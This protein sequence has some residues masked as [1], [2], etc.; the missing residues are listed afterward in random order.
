MKLREESG[1]QAAVDGFAHEHIA[2]GLLMKKYQNVSLVDFPLSTFDII[3]VIEDESGTN[4]IIR[5]Q[6]KTATTSVRFTGGSRGGV[7]REY[8]SG[9]KQYTQSTRT[10]DVVVGV[11]PVDKK[12]FDLYFVPT[13]LIEELNQASISINRIRDL[14]ENYELLENCKNTN[15]VL[16]KCKEYGILKS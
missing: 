5:A 2:A 15:F 4:N 16:E 8:L 14:R 7:D 10:S 9:V 1:R 6:S 11:H 12:S 13:I 3:I